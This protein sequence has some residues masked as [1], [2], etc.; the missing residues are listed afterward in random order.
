MKTPKL[1]YTKTNWYL[2]D[3]RTYGDSPKQ[4]ARCNNGE[5]YIRFPDGPIDYHKFTLELER[6]SGPIAE[7]GQALVE[8][9]DKWK[10]TDNPEDQVL[11]RCNYL[12]ALTMT[13]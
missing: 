10:C 1:T 13:V 7:K 4:N 2:W 3:C 9:G 8:A 5:Y 12:D 6:V 11:I